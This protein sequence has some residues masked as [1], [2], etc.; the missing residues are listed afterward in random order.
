MFSCEQ[1]GR[2]VSMMITVKTNNNFGFY[3]STVQVTIS[4]KSQNFGQSRCGYHIIIAT[5]Y[6][7]AN[8]KI[9]F[10]YNKWGLNG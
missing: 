5:F 7:Y 10:Y 1:K 4:Q 2:N 3:G 8:L 9:I 6:L